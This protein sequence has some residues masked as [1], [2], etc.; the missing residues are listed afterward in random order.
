MSRPSVKDLEKKYPDQ[1]LYLVGYGG[2]FYSGSF[3]NKEAA[4]IKFM[5][6]VKPLK[7]WGPF[8][9]QITL[10]YATR[11]VV[12]Q[13]THGGSGSEKILSRDDLNKAFSDTT[14]PIERRGGKND[15]VPAREGNVDVVKTFEDKL[16]S[17]GFSKSGGSYTK[18]YEDTIFTIK[19]ADNTEEGVFIDYLARNGNLV[20]LKQPSTIG[21]FVGSIESIEMLDGLVSSLSSKV[22]RYRAIVKALA[23]SNGDIL[24]YL[25]GNRSSKEYDVVVGTSQLL[26]SPAPGYFPEE[27]PVKFKVDSSGSNS[28]NK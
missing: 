4:K 13:K 10:G 28:L 17:L 7:I 25:Y 1:A 19:I 20:V 6:T 22:R 9:N 16:E 14:T 18:S 23:I 21:V 27:I 26:I 5:S 8:E 11:T 2:R 24:K 12:E 3:S 15:E